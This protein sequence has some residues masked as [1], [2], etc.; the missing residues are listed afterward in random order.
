METSK[1]KQRGVLNPRRRAAAGESAE[2]E[3]SLPGVELL[4]LGLIVGAAEA[5]LS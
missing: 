5:P 4:R 2:L 1:S 3:V